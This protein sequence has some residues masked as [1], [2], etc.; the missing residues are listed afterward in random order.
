M[1]SLLAVITDVKAYTAHVPSFADTWGWVIWYI[2]TYTSLPFF[3]P[4]KVVIQTD[5]FFCSDSVVLFDTIVFKASDH[6]FIL[7]AQ[8]INE[9]IRDR[10]DGELMYLTG[11]SLISSTTLNKSVHQS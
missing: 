1:S 4:F 3:F 8:E 9:R 7:T 6:P 11:E 2:Y 5:V 10:V